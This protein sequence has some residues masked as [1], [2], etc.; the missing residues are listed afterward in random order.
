MLTYKRQ[1]AEKDR[2]GGRME[3]KMDRGAPTATK[4]HGVPTGRK[5]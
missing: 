4:Q 2:K 3:K 1:L 5:I